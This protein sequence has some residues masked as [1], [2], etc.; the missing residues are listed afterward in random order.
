MPKPV[1][2]AWHRPRR[3][4]PDAHASARTAGAVKI[5]SVAA[6]VAAGIAFVVTQSAGGAATPAASTASNEPVA[7]SSSTI[8]DLRASAAPTFGARIGRRPRR[9]PAASTAPAVPAS[10]LASD[11]IPATALLAY[12]QAA[13]R[14]SAADPACGSSWP[15]LAAIGRVESDHGRFAGAI[16]HT[17]GLSTPRVIGPALDGVGTALIR[18]TDHGRLDGDRVYDHAVGPMQ[19]I[20]STWVSYGVDV[21]GSGT[22]DPFNIFDATAAAA[23]YLCDAGGTLTTLDGQR[24]AVLAYNQ[25]DAYVRL[26]LSLEAVYARG[27]PG[28]TVPVLPVNPVPVRPPAVPPVNPGP[29]PALA[30]VTT[31]HSAA[32]V[33]PASSPA[34]TAPASS[35]A[36]STVAPTGSTSA[37]S[38]GASSASPTPSPSADPSSPVTPSSS[39][40]ISPVPAPSGSS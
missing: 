5:A 1:H 37:G 14:E 6:L 12:Q 13:A 34:P 16:L 30:A 8:Q 28:L 35:A 11:G 4:R 25:S 22:A 7:D 24:R 36:A 31:S 17:D 32:H 26:V 23:H 18:D 21:T 2:F 20:P 19:F 3:V 27:V 38:S 39:P 29:P 40:S 10:D 33:G 9:R 15:L